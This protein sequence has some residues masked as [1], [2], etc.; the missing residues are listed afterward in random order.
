MYTM[1]VN[2]IPVHKKRDKLDYNIYQSISLLSN[3][4]KILEKIMHIYLTNM[5]PLIKIRFFQ[6]FEINIPQTIPSLVSLNLSNQYL[7]MISLHDL[8][9]A[10]D[11]EEYKILQSKMNHY[12]IKG[13]P[14]EWFESYLTNRQKFAVNKKQFELSSIEFGKTKAEY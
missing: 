13:I 8:Q 12:G 1:V 4:S 5:F 10:F 14:Y 7:T 3:I 9:K 11:T 2:I 6:V